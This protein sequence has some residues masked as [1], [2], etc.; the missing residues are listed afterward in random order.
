M[1][2]DY[3]EGAS[4]GCVLMLLTSHR[5]TGFP[6]QF[7]EVKAGAVGRVLAVSVIVSMSGECHGVDRDPRVEASP[8][9][10]PGDPEGATTGPGGTVGEIVGVPEGHGVQ[11]AWDDGKGGTVGDYWQL[12]LA[13]EN[14]K[15]VK[16]G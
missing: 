8:L 11:I 10:L 12:S 5:H 1:L 4:R 6:A 9:P 14:L 15:L 16:R 2:E 3:V 7:S 13:D